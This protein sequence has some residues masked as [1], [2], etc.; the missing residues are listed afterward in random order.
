LKVLLEIFIRLN[1]QFFSLFCPFAKRTEGN[2]FF[3]IVP[4]G[5]RAKGRKGLDL[6][7]IKFSKGQKEFKKLKRTFN[8]PLSIPPITVILSLIKNRTT[9]NVL[10]ID[11][12]MKQ[13]KTKAICV[14]HDQISN[15][16]FLA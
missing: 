9:K 5:K 12:S 14:N 7:L 3:I 1:S 16:S 2:S 8:H 6:F 11:A 10:C 15:N 4:F 13:C